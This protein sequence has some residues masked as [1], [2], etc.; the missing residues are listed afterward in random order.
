MNIL[1]CWRPKFSNF[2]PVFTIGLSLARFWKAFGISVH[3]WCHGSVSRRPLTAEARFRYRANPRETCSGQN[4]TGTGV[5]SEY[6]V[7][8]CKYNS[9]NTPHSS[10]S[11]TTLM[12]RTNGDTSNT[13]ILF[14]ISGNHWTRIAFILC[15]EASNGYRRKP[16]HYH[17]WLFLLSQTQCCNGQTRNIPFTSLS[18]CHSV[19]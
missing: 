18:P 10:S 8:P 13:E 5:F 3:H 14:R 9:T 2:L 19:P 4:G 11:N 17:V 16:S 7:F 6:W 1:G 15:L 12:R